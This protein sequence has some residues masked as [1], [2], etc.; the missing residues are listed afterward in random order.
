MG[1]YS[2]LYIDNNGEELA[3]VD[4]SEYIEEIEPENDDDKSIGMDGIYEP[5][6][7]TVFLPDGNASINVFQRFTKMHYSFNYDFQNKE[8]IGDVISRKVESDTDK[9]F[10]MASFYSEVSKNVLTFYRLG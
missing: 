2:V 3:E 8:K 5:F 10:P 1:K 4:V 6:I 9:N 7:T